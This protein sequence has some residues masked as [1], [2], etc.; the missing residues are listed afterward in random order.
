MVVVLRMP[1][2]NRAAPLREKAHVAERG[3]AHRYMPAELLLGSYMSKAVDVYSF[4]MLMYELVTGTQLFEGM[5]QSQAGHIHSLTCPCARS[6][7][8]AAMLA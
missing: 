5:R 8:P 4:S 7:W 3:C 2:H 6:H 1:C